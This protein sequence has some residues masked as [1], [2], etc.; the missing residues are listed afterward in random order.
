MAVSN[1]Y[2]LIWPGIPHPGGRWADLGSGA[3]A[4][5]L[6]LRAALG[7][8]GEIYSL[9]RDGKALG[10]QRRAFASAYPNA[11]VQFLQGDFTKPMNLPSLDGIVLAN[12]L[13]YVPFQE[14]EEVLR[15]LTGYLRLDGGRLIIVEPEARSGGFRVRYPVDFDSFKYL[16]AAAGLREIRRLAAVPWRLGREIYS[17]LGV[18]TP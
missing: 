5:T 1:E 9:D 18:R 14:Q 15:H 8:Q 11:K 4:F 17:A 6:A 16:A 2:D 7:P 12:A 10:R 13:H 3:G